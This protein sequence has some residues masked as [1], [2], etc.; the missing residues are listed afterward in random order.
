MVRFFSTTVLIIIFGVTAF[1][2]KES[3]EID[4]R[5]QM[6]GNYAMAQICADQFGDSLRYEVTLSKSADSAAQMRVNNFGSYGQD[7]F[8]YIDVA[9]DQTIS[10]PSQEIPVGLAGNATIDGTGQWNDNVLFF[11]F[12]VFISGIVDT[13]CQSQG[14]K[15]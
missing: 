4:P 10:I 11:D 2:C 6:V 9:S 14:N 7:N 3:Q 1:T 15:Q 12:R 8:L 13:Q 5:D